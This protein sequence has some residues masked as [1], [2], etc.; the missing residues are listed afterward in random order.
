MVF[1]TERLIVRKATDAD[2]DL[3]Y[4]LWTDPRVMVHV[5]F[6]QGLSITRPQIAASIQQQPESEFDCYLIVVQKDGETAVGE[7]KLGAPNPDGISETDIKLLPQFW[8]QGYGVEIKRALVN[9][10]FTHTDCRAVQATPNVNNIASIK[11]QEA[12]GGVRVGESVFEF[13]AALRDS[14]T[15]VHHYVYHVYRQLAATQPPEGSEPPGGSY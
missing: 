1:T 14:T 3:L 6:P 7:C 9:Y 8:R 4:Q 13:P 2:V 5:G 15:P 11:M 12:V 10:L